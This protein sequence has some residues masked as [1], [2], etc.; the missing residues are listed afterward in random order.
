MAKLLVDRK[1]IDT[2]LLSSIGYTAISIDSALDHHKVIHD[3]L[4]CSQEVDNNVKNPGGTPI[5][6]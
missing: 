4:E 6:L 2:N 5:L 1:D 3:I